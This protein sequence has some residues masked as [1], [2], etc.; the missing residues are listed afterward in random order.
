[1]KGDT[2][3]AQYYGAWSVISPDLVSLI[4]VRTAA[5]SRQPLDGDGKCLLPGDG[6]VAG[7]VGGRLLHHQHGPG[8]QGRHLVVDLETGRSQWSLFYD[9]CDHSSLWALYWQTITL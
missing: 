5:V 9:V 8:G 3:Q 4:T 1:M 7:G 2:S 6:D